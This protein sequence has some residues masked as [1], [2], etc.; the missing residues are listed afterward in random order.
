[1][2]RR[3]T[4]KGRIN[5][6]RGA[7][8][9]RAICLFAIAAAVAHAS[10]V[11]AEEHDAVC[12]DPRVRVQGQPEPRWLEPIVHACEVLHAAPD[13]DESARVRIVPA[14]HDLIV[15]VVLK[16]GR[17]ALRRVQEP[18]RL[19]TTLEALLVLPP[20]SGLASATPVPSGPPSSSE[21]PPK[22]VETRAPA[23]PP[24]TLGVEF[25][26]ALGGRIAGGQAYLSPGLAGFAQLRAGD[27]LFG[28]NARWDVVQLKD[29]VSVPNFEMDTLAVGI[30]VG[31][32]I[33]MPFGHMDLGVTPRLL[34]ETQSYEAGASTQGST[35]EAD[36]QIDVRFASF[37]RLAFSHSHLKPF[38]ELDGEISPGRLRRD[39]RM[40]PVLPALP[41]WSAGI[42]VGLL[43]GEE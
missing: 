31:R 19:E 25:G 26:G 24:P 23:Q 5:G 35:E 8:R 36:T 9:R 42:G 11:E 43:W 20:A 18:S 2:V 3:P 7:L 29:N 16:D 14:G 27:W 12:E 38:I 33:H 22:E 21:L 17:S 13:N 4:A 10:S 6:E 37:G 40:F 30:A 32:R 1:M 39:I 15:E 41:S 28:M 34:A